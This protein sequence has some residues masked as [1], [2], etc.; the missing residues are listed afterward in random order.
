[1]P[2]LHSRA[3]LLLIAEVLL[4]ATA[5]LW[6]LGSGERYW[7]VVMYSLLFCAGGYVL[8]RDRRWLI[9]Y[10]GLSLAGIVLGQLGEQVVIKA[11]HIVLTTLCYGMLFKAVLQHSF[12]NPIVTHRDRII[13]G[14]AGYILLGLFWFL[15]LGWLTFSADPQLVTQVDSGTIEAADKMYFSFVTMTTLGYGDIVPVSPLAKTIV[16]FTTISGVLYLAVFMAAL[17]GGSRKES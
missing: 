13:A 10:I 3:W 8:V 11:A 9:T 5:P 16:L 4:I 17:V 12:F 15:Q 7:P 1:M 14:V 6:G 2:K